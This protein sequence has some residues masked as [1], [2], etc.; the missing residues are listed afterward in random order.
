[1]APGM[2]VRCMTLSSAPVTP[3]VPK[4]GPQHSVPTSGRVTTSSAGPDISAMIMSLI[5]FLNPDRLRC[6]AGEMQGS[7]PPVF[8]RR[9]GLLC[10]GFT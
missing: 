8:R 6:S 9:G 4:R 7:K 1:M 3:A 2:T 5:V 10:V